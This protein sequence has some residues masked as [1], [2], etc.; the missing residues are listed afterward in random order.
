MK[1]I[2]LIDYVGLNAYTNG[3]MYKNNVSSICTCVVMYLYVERHMADIALI[4]LGAARLRDN[5][6]LILMSV[7]ASMSGT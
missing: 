4:L 6:P 2:I 7:L 5:V 1:R 3:S